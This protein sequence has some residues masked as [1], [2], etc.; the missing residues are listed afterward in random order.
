M[1]LMYALIPMAAIL[2]CG[3]GETKSEPAGDQNAAKTTDA[4]KPAGDDHGGWWCAEH[5]VPEKECSLCSAEAAANFKKAGDWCEKHNRADS[6][7]FICHPERKEHYAKL[8]RAKF[9]AEPP[10][11]AAE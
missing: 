8:Y 1:K 10:K 11:I 4:K 6:Q 3:C 2:V 9:G 5:G 7:C